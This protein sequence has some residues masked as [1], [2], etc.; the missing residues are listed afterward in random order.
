MNDDSVVRRW[1][2]SLIPFK[3][4]HLYASP[5]CYIIHSVYAAIALCSFRY[6]FI[7]A[8]SAAYIHIELFISTGALLASRSSLRALA[9]SAALIRL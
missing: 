9:S 1:D 6:E 2:D 7:G 3:S 4:S 5:V 8:G